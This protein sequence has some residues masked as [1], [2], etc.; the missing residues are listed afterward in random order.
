MKELFSALIP[1]KNGLRFL[2]QLKLYFKSVPGNFE[3]LIV[4]DDSSDGTSNFLQRWK[5]EDG[6]IS[7]IKGSGRGIVNALNLGLNATQS[8]WIF[9][10]DVDDTYRPERI[11]SQLSLLG[12]PN[13]VGGFSDYEIESDSGKHLGY[14]PS[15][16]NSSATYLSLISSNRTPHPGAMLRREALI[17]VGNYKEEDFP[18]ED[19]GLWL[20]LKNVGDLYS[21]PESLLKWRISSTSL[22]SQNRAAMKSK[23]YHLIKE[24][25]NFEYARH[26]F[27]EDSKMIIDSYINYNFANERAL[28]Y[29]FDFFKMNRFWNRANFNNV[30]FISQ[31][32]IKIE[33]TGVV[34]RLMNDRLKRNRYRSRQSRSSHFLSEP[35]LGE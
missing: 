13:I 2:P 26:R 27:L 5:R 3:I 20:R 14:I 15:A 11:T 31:H 17:E 35:S 23:K 22:T 29:I 30:R 19:L 25:F 8:E 12:E 21:I 33:N 1:V 4:D 34:V 32:L 16:I 9:R 6:R 7:V 28:L 24:L 18:C 10:F